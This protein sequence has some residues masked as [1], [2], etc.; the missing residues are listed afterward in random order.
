MK[1][2]EHI[3][4]DI[5][6]FAMFYAEFK[7]LCEEAWKDKYN[8]LLINSLEDKNGKKYMICN[9]SNPQYQI[10]IPQTDPFQ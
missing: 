2:A 8:Y 3:N 4:R 5:A 1:D 7:C 9:E 6:G 10:F